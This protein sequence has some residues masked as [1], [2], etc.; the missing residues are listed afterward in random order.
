MATQSLGGLLPPW[1]HPAARK[2]R[3]VSCNP[4]SEQSSYCSNC[5]LM[6]DPIMLRVLLSFRLGKGLRPAF[7]CQR[8]GDFL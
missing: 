5:R 1:L 3:H 7:N 4:S 2:P 6:H 8:L